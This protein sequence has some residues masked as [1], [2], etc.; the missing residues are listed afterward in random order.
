MTTTAP[1][2]AG[3]APDD[4]VLPT[5]GPPLDT[6]LAVLK[7]GLAASP[8]LRAGLAATVVM[9]LATAAGKL[10]VPVLVQQI[11]DRGITGDEGFQPSVVLPACAAAAV[12]VVV[13]AIIGRA[14]FLRLVRASE[15]ALYGLRVRA[16]AHV[17]RLSSAEHDE[18]RRGALVS[19]VTSDVETL[20]RFAEWGGVAWLVDTALIAGTLGV[21]LAYSWRLT[22]VVV[23]VFGPLVPLL[24]RLQRRQLAAYDEL[25]VRVAET[26]SEVSETVEGAAVVRAYGLE[27]AT[28]RRLA[29]SVDRQYRAYM[30]TSLYNGVLF[31]L[32]D[33]FGAVALAAVAA[34]AAW[35]GPGW[36]LQVG[37]VVAF[38]FLVGLLVNPVAE[39]TE[40][41]DRTQEALAGWRKI[42]QLLA[43]PVELVEPDPGSPLPAG[44]LDV[45]VEELRFRYRRGGDVLREVD[46]EIPAGARVAVVGRTGSGKT[47]FAALLCRF[48]DPTAGR[49]LVGGVDLREVAPEARRRAVRMVP[50][51]GFLFD[52]TIRENVRFGR[53]GA[54]DAE[55]EAAVADLGLAGWVARLPQ[56][57][58]TPAGER[59]SHLSAGE[60]QLV[61]LARA[62]LSDPGLLVLD[63]A[64]SAVDPE[65]ERALALALVRLAQGRTTIAVAHRLSTAEQADLVLVFDA[66]RLVE[67]GPHADLL[68]AGGVYARL[69]RSWLGGTRTAPTTPPA[70]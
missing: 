7:A 59:G 43:V 44:A 64:T 23:V 32:G 5:V 18:R 41:V 13:L 10:L 45:R 52:A 68:A 35:W 65:T 33:L 12:A 1:H 6:G 67:R 4:D 40:I 53:R 16:F 30:R 9:A 28:R 63:E 25:R 34:V 70:A 60:R 54:T 3:D 8:E 51:D 50:Q 38:L 62:H 49:V 31:P 26:M 36:G 19:R 22:L 69:H 11:I 47:T 15:D 57:L 24:M 56:G 61:A 48:A 14:T 58:D 66:G 27:R 39:L 21:M 42:L 29:G 46:V 20:A 17:H 37:E 55:V 2:A